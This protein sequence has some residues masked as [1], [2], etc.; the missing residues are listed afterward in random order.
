MCISCRSEY[1]IERRQR[2]KIQAIEYLGGQ[3]ADCE[4]IDIP[5]VYDFHHLN[6]SE[7]EFSFGKIH[8]KFEAIK[9]ELDKCVLLCSNC[10]R[11]R[12]V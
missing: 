7:K 6:P 4:L 9:L 5:A 8:R 3:C 11:K 2:I 10:H 1:T 12:H